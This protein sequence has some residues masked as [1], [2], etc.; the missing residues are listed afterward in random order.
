MKQELPQPPDDPEVW[1]KESLR[2]RR[3]LSGRLVRNWMRTIWRDHRQLVVIFSG[4][5]LLL[6]V[7]ILT[8]SLAT[9][10]EP[11]EEEEPEEGDIEFS[12]VA[13]AEE[14][15]PLVYL[16]QFSLMTVLFLG[17]CLIPAL[18]VQPFLFSPFQTRDINLAYPSLVDLGAVALQNLRLWLGILC[19]GAAL[20]LCG[21]TSDGLEASQAFSLILVFIPTTL[22]LGHLEAWKELRE[23]LGPGE[24]TTLQD[25][26][27]LAKHYTLLFLCFFL[28]AFYLP[29]PFLFLALGLYPLAGWFLKNW[30]K[31]IYPYISRG[32]C[33]HGEPRRNLNYPTGAGADQAQ[34]IPW[35]R[36]RFQKWILN[37]SYHRMKEDGEGLEASLEAD[38]IT[39]RRD[40]YSPQTAAF[41]LFFAPFFSFFIL[42]FSWELGHPWR[43]V[44]P[45]VP[46]LL[47]A[48]SSLRGVLERDGVSPPLISW[49]TGINQINYLL[50]IPGRDMVD[51]QLRVLFA[52]CTL[53]YLVFAL[54]LVLLRSESLLRDLFLAGAILVL[55][56]SFITSLVYLGNAGKKEFAP[57]IEGSSSG[58]GGL[59]ILDQ[60][61]LVAVWVFYGIQ[62]G[63]IP[64]L[65]A[66][67][68]AR[69]LQPVHY[70]VVITDIFLLGLL[71]PFFRARAIKAYD[72]IS[73]N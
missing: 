49:C 2:L 69:V 11:T 35:T 17:L 71:I 46:L 23:R 28:G 56:L 18:T 6:I 48:L 54:P 29:L 60:L 59:G 39:N 66:F 47:L 58:H 53:L 26:G 62:L 37:P 22:V 55:I 41:A 30:Q 25:P 43:L 27:P 50:P 51:R 45:S 32:W 42:L 57:W 1:A 4:Y 72:N 61:K 19:L 13:M 52:A 21:L 15:G 9:Q 3:E 10:D 64:F 44:P 7:F 20:V 34:E 73:I 63:L 65:G 67:L 33:Q 36:G 14:F 70:L 24:G 5:F 38:G 16:V 68:V 40:T 31:D 8:L 12:W